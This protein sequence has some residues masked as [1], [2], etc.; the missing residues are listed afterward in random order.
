MRSKLAAIAAVFVVGL[1]STGLA[2]ARGSHAVPESC[3]TVFESQV[4]TWVV[5]E[6]GSVAELGATIPLAVIEGVPADP[7]MVWPPEQLAAV[8]F[9]DEGRAAL[10]IDHLGINWEGHGHP[11]SPFAVPHFDFHLYTLSESDI[12]AIDCSDERKPVTLPAG[13]VLPDIEVPQLGTL[14]GLCVPRM[15]MHA[16]PSAQTGGDAFE[17]SMIIGYYGGHAIYFEP[18]VSQARLLERSDFSLTVPAIRDLPPGV[19][20]PSELHARYDRER[21]EYR[22]V[23]TGFHGN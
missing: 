12:E 18:M 3:T 4:C 6:R 8:S 15:G 17:A 1:A 20:Y 9:P 14:I 13:Y 22:F 10:G 7:P 2:V 5:I 23:F 16:M 19:R 21:D 11:P